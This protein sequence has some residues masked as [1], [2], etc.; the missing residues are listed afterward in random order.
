LSPKRKNN[1]DENIIS[2]AILA[3][4]MTKAMNVENS[5]QDP[6]I[7]WMEEVFH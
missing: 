1:S 4:V 3:D 2:K 5:W 6:L 7:P